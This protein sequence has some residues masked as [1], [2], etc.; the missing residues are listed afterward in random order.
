MTDKVKR[1]CIAVDIGGSHI[2]TGLVSKDGVSNTHNQILADASK[3]APLLPSILEQISPLLEKTNC[4]G[5]A[6]SF[7]GIVKDGQ[8][9]ST[10][11]GKFADAP[12]LDLARWAKSEFGLKLVMENDARMALLGEAENGAV[13]NCRDVVMLTLGTGVGSAVLMGGA[14]LRGAHFQA[15]CLGGHIPIRLNGRSCICGAIGCVE[16][17]AST[18]AL[19]EIAREHVTELDGDVMLP[20]RLDFAAVFNRS[21]NGDSFMQKLRDHC[22]QVWGAGLV[23]L[24]HAYDPSVVV[25]GGGVMASKAQILPALTE[26]IERHA[27]SWWG[28]P[29]LRAATLGAD[30]ALFGALPL[31]DEFL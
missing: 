3:L 4:R 14:L 19:S 11:R 9:L 7:P 25:I 31:M 13:K 18:W 29:E 10:P 24:I 20:T 2:R 1:R 8:V 21:A 26:Y 28:K 5:M 6:I 27:F 16:A 15:G 30:A 12:D 17:E 22:L 23:G